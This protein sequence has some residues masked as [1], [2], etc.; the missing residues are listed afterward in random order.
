LGTEV[1]CLTNLVGPWRMELSVRDNDVSLATQ[2]R[3]AA[4]MA[5]TKQLKSVQV[6]ADMLDDPPGEQFAWCAALSKLPS[7]QGVSLHFLEVSMQDLLLL[8]ALTGLSGLGLSYVWTSSSWGALWSQH[9][10]VG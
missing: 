7:L 8:T 1:P 9:S 5:A 10:L 2:E 6:S 4:A 3:A